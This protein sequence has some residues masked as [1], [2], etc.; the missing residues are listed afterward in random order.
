[1]T[2][3]IRRAGIPVAAGIA[4]AA[5]VAAFTLLYGPSPPEA[6]GSSHREAPLISTDPLAD[7]TDLYAFRSPDRPNTVTLIANYVPLQEPAGGPNFYGFGDDVAYEIHVDNDE[8]AE[9]DLTYRFEFTTTVR[10]PDTFLYNTGPIDSLT[11]S[12][13][14]VRQTYSVTRIEHRDRGRGQTETVLGE[15]LPTPPPNIGPRSTPDYDALASAAVSVLPDGT[16]VFAGQRDDPFY[17]DLGS[18]FDL[19][20]LRPFNALHA[21]P[22]VSTPGVDGL[23]GYNVHSIALQ[24]PAG[25]VGQAPFDTL[26]VYATASRPRVTVR[27]TD[28]T[29][30]HRGED[31][32]V[33]RL[34]NPLV[35]EVLIPLGKKD[36]WNSSDPLGD[37]Q[38]ESHYLS[39]EITALLNLVYPELQ[40]ARETGR[41]DIHAI[42]LTGITGFN[43]TGDT[44][45]DLLRLNFFVA[46]A[47]AVGTADR[48]GLMGGDPAGF[49]NG[50]RLEDDVVD[51]E[52]RA[53]AE[54][55]GDFLETLGLPN[56]SPNN[57]LGDGVDANDVPFVPTFPYLAAPH[58]GYGP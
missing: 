32:Q 19:L 33:S 57:L 58:R 20:G 18:A 34:G 36:L 49:P 42:L 52:L 14:N 26:G 41:N 39:P 54:G 28:G 53:L 16:L 2:P 5:A 51:I 4:L 24:L 45:A 25:V 56:L 35:N 8:N 11:D 29:Q 6:T 47:G 46:P 21:F 17:V 7:T 30:E 3:A 55:W 27:R 15:D 9:T 22:L 23:A 13:W 48:L 37:A 10:N 44:P 40:D 38:F 43:R 12:D 31:V 1:M 50:R